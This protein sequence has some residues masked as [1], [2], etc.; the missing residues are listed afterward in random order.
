MKY[1]GYVSDRSGNVTSTI[2]VD[3]RVAGIWDLKEGGE[4]PS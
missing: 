1:Y 4:N 3:G 2:L